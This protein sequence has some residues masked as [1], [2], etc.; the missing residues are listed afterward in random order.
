M[1]THFYPLTFLVVLLLLSF[2]CKKDEN[3]SPPSISLLTGTAY[4]PDKSVILVGGRIYFGIQAS[5]PSANITNLVI[6][7]IMP[8][9]TVKVVLDSGLNSSGF[10]VNETF[11]QSVEEEARWTFQ[12][13]DRNRQFATTSLT[14]FKDPNSTW[15][16]I[17][18]YPNLIM[19]YQNNTQYGQF[20]CPATGKIYNV[21]SANLYPELIDIVT[22]FYVDDNIPSPT[23]SS[24]GELGGGIT[25]Y[26]PSI[27]SWATKHYTKWD[28]SVDTDPVP[29]SAYNACHN[30]SLLILAYDDVW[31]K[32]KFKWADPG[33]ILP[34]MTAGG[35]KGLIRVISAD[36]DAA[37][38]ITFSMKIQQ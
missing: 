38:K 9:G 34:F 35:K 29:I 8:N 4:T 13:M 31:G 37:G 7:K 26:Y 20:C 15:G 11:F 30:D 17:F 6:K 23:F 36:H 21:D 33:D 22:Y 3:P 10:S 32:R 28:V 1:K 25:E 2:G 5:D 14:L 12:V 19:G 27:D 16:G 24:P 18:E